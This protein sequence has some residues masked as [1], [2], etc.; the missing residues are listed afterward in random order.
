[1]LRG[2]PVHGAGQR[3]AAADGEVSGPA[4]SQL[5]KSIGLADGNGKA[6]ANGSVQLGII[7]EISCYNYDK[8]CKY[9]YLLF[10][11]NYIIYSLTSFTCL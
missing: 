9:Y 3:P 4:P 8:Y 10:I 2:Q 11:V 6:M 1:M 7:W 5:P